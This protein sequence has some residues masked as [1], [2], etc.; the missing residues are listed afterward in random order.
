MIRGPERAGHKL[1]RERIGGEHAADTAN[2]NAKGCGL[3]VFSSRNRD[4]VKSVKSTV[5]PWSNLSE[6]GLTYD[7]LSRLE[8]IFLSLSLVI[9]NF[10]E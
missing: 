6:S 3:Q 8:P 7:K 5:K 10:Y 9:P 4:R 1:T 2:I